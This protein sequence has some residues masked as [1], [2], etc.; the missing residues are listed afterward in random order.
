MFENYA[1]MVAARSVGKFLIAVSIIA[2]LFFFVS[3]LLT[4]CTT[5][6]REMMEWEGDYDCVVMQ[7]SRVFCK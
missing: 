6:D 7:D 3:F 2:S 1:A 4:G 5:M